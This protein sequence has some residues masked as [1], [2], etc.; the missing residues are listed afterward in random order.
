MDSL[1]TDHTSCTV[2]QTDIIT[3]NSSSATLLNMNLFGIDP[4]CT[5][6]FD[7]DRGGIYFACSTLGKL[8]MFSINLIGDSNFWTIAGVNIIARARTGF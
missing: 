2:C 4:H 3:I 1:G 6:L 7:L 5:A 8:N